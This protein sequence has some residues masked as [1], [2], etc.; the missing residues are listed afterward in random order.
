[1]LSWWHCWYLIHIRIDPSRHRHLFLWSAFQHRFPWWPCKW[2]PGSGWCILC[3]CIVFITSKFKFMVSFHIFFLFVDTHFR[4]RTKTQCHR[5]CWKR[6]R[7]TPWCIS[8]QG[9]SRIQ[10]GS[11]QWSCMTD[12]LLC[13][14]EGNTESQGKWICCYIRHWKHRTD[15]G[16]RRGCMSSLPP[17]SRTQQ[18]IGEMPHN[19]LALACRSTF[20]SGWQHPRHKWR[21]E[22]RIHQHSESSSIHCQMYKGFLAF[23]GQHLELIV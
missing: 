19:S 11:G 1:M 6:E 9:H 16:W 21:H 8:P 7:Q 13:C 17:S 15:P 14:T 2:L 18:H 4:G 12:P 20:L 3:R 23:R 22:N 5:Q 10:A